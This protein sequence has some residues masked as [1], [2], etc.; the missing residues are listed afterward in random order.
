[1]YIDESAANEHTVHC[2]YSW[3]PIGTPARQ[4]GS[5]TRAKKWSILPV[6]T[7]EGFMDWKIIQGSFN[8]DLFVKFLEDHVI[9]HSNPFPG[10]NSVLIMDNARIHHDPVCSF[11]VLLIRACARNMR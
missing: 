9:P 11:H 7:H 4:V 3:V 5:I 8:A 10:C 2:R 6:Y 1:M